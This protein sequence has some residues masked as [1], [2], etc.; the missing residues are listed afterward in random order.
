MPDDLIN[1]LPDKILEYQTQGKDKVA[2]ELCKNSYKIVKIIEGSEVAFN[3]VLA[4]LEES[5]TID[6]SGR[7]NL[8]VT[9][10]SLDKFKKRHNTKIMTEL[11]KYK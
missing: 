5:D 11:E 4:V 7:V 1:S 9:L 6:L 10:L 8:A 3:L 2:A